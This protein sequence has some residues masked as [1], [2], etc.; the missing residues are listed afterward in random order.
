MSQLSLDGQRHVPKK[1]I[2]IV[3]GSLRVGGTEGSAYSLAKMLTG[4]G[5]HVMLVALESVNELVEDE[6]VQVEYLVHH[7]VNW[8][9]ISRVPVVR[10]V[11]FLTKQ[12]IGAK[13]FRT[14]LVKSDPNPVVIAFGA[15]V[16]VWSHFVLIGLRVTKWGFERNHP[17]SRIRGHGFLT[18]LL[19]PF[20]YNHG[21]SCLVQTGEQSNWIL[22]EWQVSSQVVPNHLVIPEID[23][24][25]V[26]GQIRMRFFAR[27]VIWIGRDSNQ[28]NLPLLLEVVRVA[29]STNSNL[30]FLILGVAPSSKTS[31]Q[32]IHEGAIVCGRTQA[33]SE[34]LDSSSLLLSTSRFEGFPNVV[35]EA[36]HRGLP[37]VSTPSTSLFDEWIESGAVSIQQDSCPRGLVTRIVNYLEDL[38]EYSESARKSHN[39]SLRYSK[40]SMLEVWSGLL[41]K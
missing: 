10:S 4:F 6:S 7:Q 40:K 35:I 12:L 34:Y 17:D 32:L 24:N 36:L 30:E 5:H 13:R 8:N 9:R 31:L 21:T 23:R 37:V 18:S 33:V 14:M 25:Q 39:L 29:R 3:V 1:T 11:F 41:G 2:F 16:A 15:T 38:D 28:K 22:R 26:E 27:R 20:I 19:R